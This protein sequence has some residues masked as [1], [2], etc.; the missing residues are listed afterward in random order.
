MTV[1]VAVTTARRTPNTLSAAFDAAGSGSQ[2][3]VAYFSVDPRMSEQLTRHLSEDGMLDSSSCATLEQAT[4]DE[5]E[6]RGSG[7][8]DEIRTEAQ[9]RSVNC[10]TE[11][12]RGDFIEGCLTVAKRMDV[13]DVFIPRHPESP[14][15]RYLFD[16]GI[17]ARLKRGGFAVHV[18]EESP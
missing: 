14:L 1:L 13:A 6:S 9:D 10:S 2:D 17:E 16:G 15:G 4:L 8:L 18:V 5:Y 7:K 12:D 11:F 3:M